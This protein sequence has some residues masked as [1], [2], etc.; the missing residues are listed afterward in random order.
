MNVELWKHFETTSCYELRQ[1]CRK[2]N[3][4]SPW[5]SLVPPRQRVIN[6]LKPEKVRRVSNAASKIRST[7]LNQNLSTGLDVLAKPIGLLLNFREQQPDG[8]LSDIEGMFMQ[9]AIR[10]DDEAELRFLW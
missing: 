10:H 5:Q 3:K 6:P 8:V 7:S 2:K 9:V 4:N 1:T